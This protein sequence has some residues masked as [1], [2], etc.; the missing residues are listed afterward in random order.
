MKGKSKKVKVKSRKRKGL[1]HRIR[2]FVLRMRLSHACGERLDT[3]NAPAIAPSLVPFH[4]LLP[5]S[6]Y[7]FNFA[8]LISL[9]APISPDV[10]AGL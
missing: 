9:T 6:F 7:I 10:P 3:I 5:L 2:N 8:F 4:F 1:A